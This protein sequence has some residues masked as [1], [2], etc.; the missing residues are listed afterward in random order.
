MAG[1]YAPD[2]SQRA[3][4][5]DHR[6][7]GDGS[8]IGMGRYIVGLIAFTHQVDKSYAIGLSSCNNEPD[9]AGETR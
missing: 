5:V 3:P 1:I 8:A 9:C 2:L 6:K 4:I 7:A